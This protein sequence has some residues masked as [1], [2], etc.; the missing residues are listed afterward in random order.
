MD[1]DIDGTSADDSTGMEVPNGTDD[2]ELATYF[3]SITLIVPA[4]HLAVGF[5]ELQISENASEPLQWC[6]SFTQARLGKWN[7]VDSRYLTFTQGVLFLID[8]I[9]ECGLACSVIKSALETTAV[10]LIRAYEFLQAATGTA[11]KTAV[12]IAAN[13]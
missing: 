9:P 12:A 8:G 4:G 1:P 7:G 5:T 10:T 2:C 11:I 6:Y 13:A 3:G